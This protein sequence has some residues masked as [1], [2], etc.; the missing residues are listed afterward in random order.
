MPTLPNPRHECFARLYIQTG[1]AAASY[2]KAGFTPT[3]RSGLDAAACRLARKGKT[4]RR[5]MELRGQLAKRNAVTLDTLLDDLA[6]DRVLA[7]ELGQP[8]A[9]ITA[10]MNQARLV[11]LLVDRKETGEPG[12]FA[13]VQTEEEILEMVRAELGDESAATLAAALSKHDPEAH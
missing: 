1:N 5:I 11:G 7:R 9:A 2:R 4:Q 12:R 10:T 3:T 6:A 13:A 8:A